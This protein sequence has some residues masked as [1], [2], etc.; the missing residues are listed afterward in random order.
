MKKH[1]IALPCYCLRLLNLQSHHTAGRLVLTFCLCLSLLPLHSQAPL[2]LK[3][4]AVLRDGSGQV[5]VSQA[6]SVVVDILR[7][8]PS[9]T[10]LFTE[11]HDVTTTDQGLINL[12]IGSVN[13]AGLA[14]IDWADG[15]YFL[16][17]TIGDVVMGTSQLVSVPYALYAAKTNTDAKF[18]VRGNAGN[19]P[20][21]ALFAVKDQFG[22][23]VFAVYPDG[24]EVIVNPGSK[25][26]RGG[27]AVGGR[28]AVKSTIQDLMRITNDSVRI[29]I[30]SNSLAKGGKGGFAVG[31][32]NC[33]KGS[34]EQY[35]LLTPDN[36]FI[37]QGAGKSITT[38]IHNSFMGYR[39]GQNTTVG[40]QNVYLGNHAGFTADSAESNIIIGDSA[41][42]F[43]SNG[44]NNIFLGTTAGFRNTTGFQ[45]ICLGSQSGYSLQNG[46]RNIMIGVLSGNSLT[47]G[48]AN[49]FIGNAAGMSNTTGN[50]NVYVGRVA[51]LG[52]TTG[53]W[54]VFLGHRA[55]QN[56]STGGDNIFI[57]ESSG[58][59]SDTSS[60][61]IYIGNSS[62]YKSKGGAG[63]VFLGN[64]T[65]YENT[66]GDNNTF[67]GHEN[68]HFN[69]SGELNSFFGA[70]AGYS[71]TTGTGNTFIG[72]SAGRQNGAGS[73]NTYLGFSTGEISTGSGNVF[74]GY[75]AGWGE[76]GSN[77]LY[78]SNSKADMFNALIYGEFDTKRLVVNGNLGLGV[79]APAYRIE[80]PNNPN[81]TGQGR[82]NAW[83]TY[84][85]ARYKE[86]ISSITGALDL[87][88]KLNGVYFDWK[89][90]QIRSSGLIAQEVEAIIPMLV[91]T[92]P[93][94]FKSIDYSRLTAYLVNA[95][96]EQQEQIIN[97][98]SQLNELKNL[99]SQMNEMKLLLGIRT[100][101]K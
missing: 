49:V 4:Q 93:K 2:I 42:Y 73:S 79:S 99:Q 86:N 85:D 50:Y 6:K 37:G 28:T 17:I 40:S 81:E 43:T 24:A 36:Y 89:G 18:E 32:R 26:G 58:F 25:G 11:H 70:F 63:N 35:T 78:I 31:G 46:N 96:K 97:L 53:S 51:G 48:L 12:E 83:L 90:S 16:R 61:N 84:S 92:D 34:I 7:D 74:L 20:D 3:Y 75:G 39:A 72:L 13:S 10:V 82:A 29:Y 87:V 65:G 67:V 88:V 54:N 76:P 94:G 5:I 57:G 91:S 23:V 1:F 14:A 55:G 15:P 21:S 62:G 98:K 68:A 52:S 22:R 71:N 30:N 69:S 56:N 100:D 8:N 59:N 19:E 80:L 38:G 64:R 47:D 27:F 33:E 60:S 41:G 66:T 95:I 45:N 44:W 9:G 101:I 77:K